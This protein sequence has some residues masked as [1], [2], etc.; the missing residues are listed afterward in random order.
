[1]LANGPA[2]V[3]QSSANAASQL[4]IA[5]YPAIT[6]TGTVGQA[7]RIDYATTITPVTNWTTLK[8]VTLPTSA[9]YPVLDYSPYGAN[10]QRFYRAV[11]VSN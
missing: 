8:Y 10:P 3:Q 5:T 4:G 7:Y 6:I 2:F 11:S 9:P 1:M